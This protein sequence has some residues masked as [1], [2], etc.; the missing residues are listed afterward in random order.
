MVGHGRLSPRLSSRRPLSLGATSVF[1]NSHPLSASTRIHS[2]ITCA[3]TR[4]DGNRF[5][6]FQTHH[7]MRL[8]SSTR[9]HG[10]IQ[11]FVTYV[12]TFSSRECVSN[13]SGSLPPS[14][15]WITLQRLSY[16]TRSL[17]DVTINPPAQTHCGMLMDII[18]LG[19]GEL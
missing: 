15:V 6:L 10:Q 3:G 11:G 7:L 14:A 9:M 13:V 5:Q 2:R 16:V 8:S 19:C 17:K 1:Q 12:D 18:N 4:L